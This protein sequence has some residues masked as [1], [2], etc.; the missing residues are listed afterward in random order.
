M[1]IKFKNYSI[2]KAYIFPGQG[3]QSKNM[4]KYIYNTSIQGRKLFDISNNIL[5][6]DILEIMFNNDEKKIK[7]TLINQ[8][9]IYIYTVIKTKIQNNFNPNMV[10]GHS[11][12]EYSALT[13]I[14]SLKF[15]DGLKIIK[16]RGEIM[17]K[18]CKKKKLKMLAV[19]G[20]KDKKIENICKKYNNNIT[21][22][23]YNYNGQ[24][25]LS[26]KIFF[27]KKI[28]KMF[29][30]LR[31]KTVNIPIEGGFHTP[32]M[33]NI[34]NKFK[35]KIKKTKIYKPI[36]PIYQNFNAKKTTNPIIIKNNLIKQITY[37]V[38]WKQTIKNM[39]KDGAEKFIEIGPKKILTKFLKKIIK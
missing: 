11:L 23:I 35:K 31:V 39:I 3:S 33:R 8:L 32:L 36:C 19:L 30:Q 16:Y 9:S 24:I 29:K 21:P 26:G 7:N 17:Q 12:G 2:I 5:N 4:G 27:I 38:K 10:A 34:V 14:N 28:K 13:A 25:V 6:F 15:E 22:S 1:C 37:P 18:I 20:L